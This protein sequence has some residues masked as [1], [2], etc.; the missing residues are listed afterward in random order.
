[1]NTPGNTRLVNERLTR[2]IVSTLVQMRGEGLLTSGVQ[3]S[4]WLRHKMADSSANRL[5]SLH[6]AQNAILDALSREHPYAGPG[7]EIAYHIPTL[8]THLRHGHIGPSAIAVTRSGP[9]GH[10]GPGASDSELHGSSTRGG[11]A[12]TVNML[13]GDILKL[14]GRVGAHRSRRAAPIEVDQP[15]AG[16]SPAPVADD[17]GGTQSTVGVTHRSSAGGP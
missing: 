13:G 15:W 2:E 12:R 16:S 9:S 1:M 4:A 14:G 10:I 11:R 6:K 5:A 3:F 17:L 8:Q 7:D